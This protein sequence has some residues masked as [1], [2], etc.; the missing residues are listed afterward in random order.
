MTALLNP[1]FQKF[2]I[3]LGTSVC[4]SLLDLA[5][6]WVYAY[7]A[8]K[9]NPFSKGISTN[10]G[11]SWAL[12]CGACNQTHQVAGPLFLDPFYQVTWLAQMKENHCRLGIGA[13]QGLRHGIMIGGYHSNHW[14]S[15]RLR[16]QAPELLTKPGLPDKYQGHCGN[17]CWLHPLYSS[18]SIYLSI[19][20]LQSLW[21]GLVSGVFGVL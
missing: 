12:I 1:L 19:Y 5:R 11:S 18:S 14:L 17:V 16:N 4:R 2:S 7:K 6:I 3:W 8:S 15:C 20:L 10:M 21:L 13:S 9:S